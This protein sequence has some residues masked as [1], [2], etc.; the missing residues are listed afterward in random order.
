MGHPFLDTGT[1]I[2]PRGRNDA[3]VRVISTEDGN[4]AA[5]CASQGH[6]FSRG[7]VLYPTEGRD[8]VIEGPQGV[9]GPASQGGR[10]SVVR[11]R[12][13][14]TLILFDELEISCSMEVVSVEE[15]DPGPHRVIVS[16]TSV[17]AK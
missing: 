17:P 1:A 9:L 15:A 8:P 10:Q 4:W 2:G 14:P 13:S 5:K 6:G 3:I 12:P 16:K 11:F 7:L